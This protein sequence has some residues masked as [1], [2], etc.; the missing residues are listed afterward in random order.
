MVDKDE[1]SETQAVGIVV[2]GLADTARQLYKLS[3]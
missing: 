3:T 1:L 2:R